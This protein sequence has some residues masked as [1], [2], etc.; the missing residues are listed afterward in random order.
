MT[1]EYKSLIKSRKQ[2]AKYDKKKLKELENEIRSYKVSILTLIKS[3]IPILNKR[4]PDKQRRA[5][6]S[7]KLHKM[8]LPTLRQAGI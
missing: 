2:I 6:M 3:Y 8:G 4:L 7:R 5:T 1:G